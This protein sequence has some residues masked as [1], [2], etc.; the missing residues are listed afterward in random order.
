VSHWLAVHL[1]GRGVVREVSPS[2]DTTS[3]TVR[4]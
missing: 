4:V 3:G 2:A 1:R